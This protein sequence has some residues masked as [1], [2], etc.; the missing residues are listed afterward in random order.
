MTRYGATVTPAVPNSSCTAFA[1]AANPAPFGSDTGDGSEW[2]PRSRIATAVSLTMRRTR[3][4]TLCIVSPGRMR[5]FTTAFASIG[6]TFVFTPP[7]TIVKAVV[8][9]S[10]AALGGFVS[11]ALSTTGRNS[12]RV[13][14]ASRLLYGIAGE[15]A[16]RIPRVGPYSCALLTADLFVVAEGEVHGVL[17]LVALT[18]QRLDCLERGEHG[19]L[20]VE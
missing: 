5:K 20:V 12:Q 9:R 3:S 13:D 17:R 8:V 2:K 18:E 15:S 19:Q 14:I 4:V 1:T 16:A 6:S 11:I 7:L 10:I